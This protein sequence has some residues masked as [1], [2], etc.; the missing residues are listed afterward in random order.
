MVLYVSVQNS[1]AHERQTL[2]VWTARTEHRLSRS[3]GYL[4]APQEAEKTT[5]VKEEVKEEAKNEEIS[6]GCF[7]RC[8]WVART[9]V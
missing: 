9:C 8:L 1:K 4:P 2:D 7:L 5:E 6:V 3:F